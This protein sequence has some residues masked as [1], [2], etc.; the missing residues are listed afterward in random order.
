[1][2]GEV[3]LKLAQSF[4]TATGT[5]VYDFDPGGTTPHPLADQNQR[6]QLIQFLGNSHAWEGLQLW[7]HSQKYKV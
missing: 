5:I 4:A 3:P 1:M 7:I 6:G 2:N